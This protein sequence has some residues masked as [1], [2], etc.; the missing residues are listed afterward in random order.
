M[1]S[2]WSTQPS[3]VMLMLKV[4]C[5]ITAK[6]LKVGWP[7]GMSLVDKYLVTAIARAL[8][9]GHR[10]ADRRQNTTDGVESLTP[11]RRV[12]ARSLQG[13]LTARAPSNR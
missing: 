11:R 6:L 2:R 3:M 7:A 1:P 9:S 4:K 8:A 5:P 10:I 13:T 12:T